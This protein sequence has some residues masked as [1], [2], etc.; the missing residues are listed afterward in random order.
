[1]IYKTEFSDEELEKVIGHYSESATEI[2]D[3]SV[4]L[5]KFINKFRT[6][7]RKRKNIPILGRYADDLATMTELVEDYHA[8][9]YRDISK[10]NIVIL[11]VVLAYVL[12]PID[13]IPDALPIIGYVDDAAIIMFALKKCLTTEI[14]AYKS[15]RSEEK[16]NRT[17]ELRGKLISA[18]E[19]LLGEKYLYVAI[20]TKDNK[21]RFLIGNERSQKSEEIECYARVY[22]I[23]SKILR[24]YNIN[25]HEIFDLYKSVIKEMDPNVSIYNFDDFEEIS[26]KYVILE[27]D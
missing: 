5:E 19:K 27:E 16:E 25:S 26:D 12:S 4:E 23:P 1:M 10:S 7:L 8:D 3:D 24:D 17:K 2:L 15:F 18:Y 11:I 13:L 20:I 9:V 22:D 21:I 14:E 6:W